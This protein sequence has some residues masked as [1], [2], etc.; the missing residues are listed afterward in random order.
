MKDFVKDTNV[1]TNDCIRRQDAIEA[2]RSYYDEFDTDER[3]IEERVADLPSAERKRK[4][5]KWINKQEHYR[6][7]FVRYMSCTCS[8]CHKSFYIVP[9]WGCYHHCPSCGAE[10]E[11]EP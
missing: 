5:G 7:P 3:S 11:V 1:P 4:K 10:M 9:E 8:A 2:I 6:V